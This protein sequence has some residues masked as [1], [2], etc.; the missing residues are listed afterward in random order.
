MGDAQQAGIADTSFEKDVPVVVRGHG[1]AP[2][3]GTH[4]QR[5]RGAVLPGASQRERLAGAI[6]AYGPELARRIRYSQGGSP[7]PWDWTTAAWVELDRAADALARGYIDE[8]WQCFHA[9]RRLEMFGLTDDEVSI[10]AEALYHEAENK[11]GTTSWRGR[12]ALDILVGIRLTGGKIPDVILNGAHPAGTTDVSPPSAS[13]RVAATRRSVDLADTARASPPSTGGDARQNP[14][15]RLWYAAFLIDGRADNNYFKIQVVR[16]HTLALLVILSL[17]AL[18]VLG[19][20]TFAPVELGRD[21][22]DPFSNAWTPV[23]VALFGVMGASMSAIQ[24]LT[25]NVKGRDAIGIPDHI[26]QGW[27]TLLRPSIGAAAALLL[28]AAIAAGVLFEG[29]LNLPAILVIAFAAGF[30]ERLVLRVVESVSPPEES[31]RGS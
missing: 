7:D 18:T 17:A 8:G 14:R 31:A 24:T 1:P 19:L 28:F 15:H 13:V 20:L 4:W 21:G 30:S 26:L 2:K 12:T 23:T 16:R 6:T 22:D 25:R 27:V 10:R 9:A 5:F 3:P 29:Q 11:L